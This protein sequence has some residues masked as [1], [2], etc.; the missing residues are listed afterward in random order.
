MD[1]TEATDCRVLGN[2]ADK[3]PCLGARVMGFRSKKAKI[4]T[5]ASV[6][7]TDHEQTPHWGLHSYPRHQT[8]SN[9]QT[10]IFI[11]TFVNRTTQPGSIHICDQWFC[12]V[13][14]LW[15]RSPKALPPYPQGELRDVSWL[16]DNHHPR[17]ESRFT[18][19]YWRQWGCRDVLKI[20]ELLSFV[21]AGTATC[22]VHL[23]LIMDSSQPALD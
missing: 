6:L 20:Q 4:A 2:C 12:K 21:Q 17:E 11:G 1:D 23:L 15:G 18:T 9:P 16:G 22:T 13:S 7:S 19:T 3:W 5:A 8:N 14:W 10:H